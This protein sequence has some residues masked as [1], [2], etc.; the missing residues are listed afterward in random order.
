MTHDP[1][2]SVPGRLKRLLR[3]PEPLKAITAK[4]YYVWLVVGTIC[5]GAF[6]AQVD[7]SIAQLVLPVL[8]KDFH[9]AIDVVSWVAII[10]LLVLAVLL[11]IFGRLADILGHKLLYVVGFGVFIVGSGLSGL[12]PDIIWLIAFRALQA[13]GAA[14]LGANSVAIVVSTAGSARRGRAIGLQATAQAVG[15][16]TG[17]ALGGLI[18]GTLG[19]RWVFFVNVPVGLIGMVLGYLVLPKTKLPP[20]RPAFDWKGACLLAP[21]LATLTLAINQ[22]GSL[23]LGSPWVWGS[24]IA[25]VSLIGAFILHEQAQSSPLL[26]LALFRIWA[27]TAGNITGLLA[28]AILFAMFFLMPFVLEHSFHENSISAGMRLSVIPVMLG[29][30]APIAGALSDKI[31]VRLLSVAG[32]LVTF[33]GLATLYVFLDG[34]ASSVLWITVALG[35]VGSGQGLFTAPNN[36][37]I[38]GAASSTQTGEAGGLLNLMRAMGTSMGIAVAAALLSLGLGVTSGHSHAD[39]SVTTSLSA[40]RLVVATFAVGALIAAAVSAVRPSR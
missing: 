19:W 15:L 24:A 29:L 27:F 12:A 38:M 26:D 2:A 4:P 21:G 31:G 37:A 16:S 20:Q 11:P 17:P 35:G 13:I 3:E 1:S 22:A 32:M 10:Y 7:S 18:I 34:K 5:V 6:M 14:L 39:A 9:A 33:A 30:L 40:A 36:S 8:E 28:N 23:G 25:S